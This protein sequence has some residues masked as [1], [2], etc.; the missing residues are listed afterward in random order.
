VEIRLL[1][2]MNEPTNKFS[3]SRS[4]TAKTLL[5]T[6]RKVQ[7]GFA[8]AL[9]CLGIIGAMSYLSVVRSRGDAAWV[10]HTHDVI[11][12]L[13]LLFSTM[14]DSQN[15]YRGFAITGDESYLKPNLQAVQTAEADVRRLRELTTDNPA[16][17]RRLDSLAPVIAEQMLFSRDVIE[18]RRSQGFEAARGVLLTGKGKQQ[19]DRIRATIDEMK[20]TEKTLLEKRELR[21]R[22]GAT[23]TQSAIIGGS[24]FA[25]AFVGLG[26]VVIR[27]DFA[28]RLRAEQ[29]LREAK[30]RLEVRV[31]ERTAELAQSEARY[32]TLF[33]TLIEGF[34][35]IEMIFDAA[36]AP[37][38][39]RFLEINPAFEKQTGLHNVQGRLMRDLAPDHE[40]HWFEIYGRIALTGEP[41]QFESEAR[42]LGRHYS[43]CAYRVGGPESRT[44]AVLFNDST[45]RTRAEQ[46]L[47]KSEERFRFLNNLTEAT[48][49]LADPAQIMAVMAR[50]L[51]QHL[52]ASRCAYADVEGDGEQFTI[53]HDYTDGCASTV[54]NYQLSHFGAR[55]VRTLHDGQTLIIRDVEEE[56]LPDDGGDM[57]NA[58]GIKAI[59]TCPLVKDGSLRALMAVHQ[60][61]PRDW[62]AGE[63]AIVQD[64]VERCWATIERRT[65]EEKIHQLNN[66]LEQRVTERTAQL[67]AANKELEAFSYSVSHD[68]RA[69]LRGMGGYVRMLKEDCGDRLDAE[70]NRLLDVVSS[71]AKRM[72]QLIDDLLAFS[73]LG[74]EQMESTAIDMTVLARAVFESPSRT[75]PK[76]APRFELKSLPLAQGDLGMLRQVFVNLIGNAVKFTRHQS[77]PEVEVGSRSGD[78]ETTYY[79]RDN[80]VGFDE[81]YGHKLFGVFQ[82]LHSEDEFEGT[83]VGLALVQRVIQRHGG[84]VWAEGKPDQG[85]TFYFS[86]PNPNQH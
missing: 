63:I 66:E 9:V 13:E 33:E 47:R 80:G 23:V 15:R 37:V 53:L 50:M 35:T 27:R 25:F 19:H 17:Q 64:V 65:A 4:V 40:A 49:T 81:K 52:H 36:G 10:A 6:E 26:V 24:L 43:V 30:D 46:A 62:Q 77:A 72:G 61:T 58:V 54:G 74:R 78:G 70:G 42:A 39:Y 8:F 60:T 31:T 55:A 18:T 14:S 44:V 29:A 2:T 86:L 59:I 3:L 7:A 76:S 75:D 85:A 41:A 56:L 1:I 28:G 32:R 38:D 45:E 34:C 84:K 71:E 79:V 57:F 68:L 48:R 83:G 16:Q 73:R 12:R 67:E 20:G 21:A 22:R 69:P 5:A 82:R 11:S 51:G